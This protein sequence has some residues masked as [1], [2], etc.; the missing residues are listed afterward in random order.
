MTFSGEHNAV[1]M[2]GIA[3]STLA[4]IGLALDEKKTNIF[5]RGRRQSCTGLVVNEK[6]NVNRVYL[7][8]LRAAVHALSLEKE[9]TWDGRPD[10]VAAVLG[11]IHFVNAVRPEKARE[12]IELLHRAGVCL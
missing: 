3:Q 5:R 4:R 8:K 1:K 6:V 12:L 2:I 9:P 10:S 7:R 11:R